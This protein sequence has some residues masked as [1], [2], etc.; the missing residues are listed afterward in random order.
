MAMFNSF[1]YV[2]QRVNLSKQ[3]L[4]SKRSL[5]TLHDFP[6]GAPNFCFLRIR[7]SD[8]V[9]WSTNVNHQFP[10]FSQLFHGQE[11]K[12]FSF[13]DKQKTLR[14]MT[15]CANWALTVKTSNRPGPSSSSGGGGGRRGRRRRG[16]GG[17]Q[18][19]ILKGWNRRFQGFYGFYDVFWVFDQKD[20]GKIQEKHATWPGFYELNQNGT[21][22]FQPT[23]TTGW[24]MGI[25][26]GAQLNRVF[27]VKGMANYTEL[28]K[29]LCN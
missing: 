2:Y 14:S 22:R 21:A 13:S 8:N 18:I 19:G 28:F 24:D 10:I 9:T 1:L 17:A 7:L 27:L 5:E 12:F 3:R 16:R 25:F 26:L 11:L 15:C 23:N 6:V 29:E 20:T 4:P